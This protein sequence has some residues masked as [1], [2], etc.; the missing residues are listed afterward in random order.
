VASPLE[1]LLGR[2]RAWKPAT[3]LAKCQLTPVFAPPTTA[4]GESVQIV[5]SVPADLASPHA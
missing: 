5:F 2:A 4:T 1:V 3:V